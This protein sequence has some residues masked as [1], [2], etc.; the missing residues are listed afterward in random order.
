MMTIASDVVANPFI[1]LY[2]HRTMQSYKPHPSYC[3]MVHE[4]LFIA[5]FVLFIL[6]KNV[7]FYYAE[8][9]ETFAYGPWY[10]LI[11]GIIAIPRYSRELKQRFSY[12]KN[13]NL[14]WLRAIFLS[15]VFILILW[16]ANS[17]C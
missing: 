2:P 9:F 14:N 5:P 10:L 12:T 15:F 4:L 3:I 13:I 11:W 17:I 6:S 7:L 16:I 8:V 1:R